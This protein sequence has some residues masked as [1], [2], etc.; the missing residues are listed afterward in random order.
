MA[1]RVQIKIDKEGI[2]RMLKGQDEGSKLKET[3]SD[4]MDQVEAAAAADVPSEWHIDRRDWVGF[5]R[6][7]ATAGLPMSVESA[8]G[9]LQRALGALGGE[10]KVRYTTKA[11]KTRWATEAQV[12]NWTR[13]SRR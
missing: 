3:L 13:G 6:A 11:G 12:R 5:D 1:K 2:G 9:A 4:L 7:R 10:A 8:T